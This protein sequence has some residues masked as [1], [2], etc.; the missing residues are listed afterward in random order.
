MFD[1][2]HVFIMSRKAHGSFNGSINVLAASPCFGGL[3]RSVL[4]ETK[5]KSVSPSFQ[6][7]FSLLYFYFF[8]FV[9]ETWDIWKMWNGYQFF[10]INSYT[11]AKWTKKKNNKKKKTVENLNPNPEASAILSG[12]E[13]T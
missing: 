13:T 7:F 3:R 5:Y 12:M 8:N 2:F 6:I 4:S 1:F 11:L 10:P 9:C